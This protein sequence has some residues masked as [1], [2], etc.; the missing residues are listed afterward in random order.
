[1]RRNPIKA[2]RFDFPLEDFWLTTAR[3]SNPAAA[4]RWIGEDISRV[5]ALLSSFKLG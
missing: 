4:W 1:M 5:E 3:T 2:G